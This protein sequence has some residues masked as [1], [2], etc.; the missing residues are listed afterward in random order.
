[1]LVYGS[2]VKVR[3]LHIELALWFNSPPEYI[4]RLHKGG[5]CQGGNC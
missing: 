5:E 3:E 1:M 4:P 2:R